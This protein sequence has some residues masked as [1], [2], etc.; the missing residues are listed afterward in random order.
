MGKQEK[1][2]EDFITNQYESGIKNYSDYTKNVGLWES[3]EHVFK[4]YLDTSNQ[5]LD[6]GCGTGRTTFALE[7]LGFK[8]IIGV[9]LTSEMIAEA[10]K[11]NQ[12]F[13]KNID[14]RVGDARNLQ[15]ID[16]AFDAVIFSF[17]GL[18]SIPGKANRDQAFSD[19]NRV[20]KP[21]GIFVFTT[22]D[23]DKEL[24]FL[25]FW[26]EEAI[27]WKNGQQHPKLYEFGDLITH[28][29]NETREIYIH[30]PDQATILNCLQE[31][32]FDLL[33]TFYR[34]DRF[35]ESEMITAM[36]GECRFWIAK[37]KVF[38]D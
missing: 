30:I 31:N 10:L 23:R 24:Q 22:H 14:F 29:K 21:H 33:E 16:A 36:S 35:D 8:N 4:Q 9:D 32:G 27:R 5:I 34:I 25:E 37:K 3:E 12:H 19:I 17:N 26:K 38:E 1:I 2:N 20:L 11:L 18:M 7:Q 13:D 28:S 15:F 6:L